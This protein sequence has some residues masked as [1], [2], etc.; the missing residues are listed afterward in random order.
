MKKKEL[1]RLQA[2]KSA[3]KRTEEEKSFFSNNLQKHQL[4]NSPR[5]GD[6]MDLTPEYVLEIQFHAEDSQ[7]SQVLE[8]ENQNSHIRASEQ[9]ALPRFKNYER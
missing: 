1:H 3:Q 9:R 4:R 8:L 2:F 7:E 5:N 6:L